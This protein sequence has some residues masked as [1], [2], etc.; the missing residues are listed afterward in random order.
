MVVDQLR[1][2]VQMEKGGYIS[3]RRIMNQL[4]HII[5]QKLMVSIP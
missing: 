1:A 4:Y 3:A 2:T 5:K